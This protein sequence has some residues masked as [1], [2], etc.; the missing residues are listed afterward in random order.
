MASSSSSSS[1]GSKAPKSVLEK[2]VT[3][4]RQL[5]SPGGSSGQ[6]VQKL[7]ASEYNYNNGVAIKKAL[8][9][10]SY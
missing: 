4:I 1:K 3:A 10:L 7:L 9:V 2:I 5:Q 6:A 8:K